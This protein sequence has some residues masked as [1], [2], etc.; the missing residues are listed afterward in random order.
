M[1]RELTD[2]RRTIRGFTVASRC[3]IVRFL[4]TFIVDK[5][6]A[7]EVYFLWRNLLT[8]SLYQIAILLI[9]QFRGESI[10]N[11]SKAVNNTLIFNTFVLCQIF[12]EFNARSME[13]KNV[14]KGVHRNRLFMGIIAVT[15]VLQVVMVEFLKKF[16]DTTNLNWWQWLLCIGVAA[17]TWPIGW[18][19]KLFPV[20]DKPSLFDYLKSPVTKI[21]HRT[22]NSTPR[23]GLG[24]C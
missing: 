12:N 17:V 1:Y 10:L 15:L 21:F 23:H 9:L 13:K 2:R 20:P 5:G 6:T 11:V 22:E 19:V 14:F 16:A 24:C 18:L 3:Y 7:K 8:Q 4:Y